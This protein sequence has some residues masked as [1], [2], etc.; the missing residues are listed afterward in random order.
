MQ[1]EIKYPQF[2]ASSAGYSHREC[3]S[4]S[5]VTHDTE[6]TIIISPTVEY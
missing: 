2:H 5:S 4:D 1:F 6:L 3:P